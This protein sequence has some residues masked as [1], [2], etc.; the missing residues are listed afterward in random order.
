MFDDALLESRKTRAP[1]ARRLSLPVALG[2]HA[3]VIGAFVGA[4]AWFP[5]EPPEPAEKAVV[6]IVFVPRRGPDSA[7]GGAVQ[8]Q[9]LGSGLHINRR[10]VQPDLSRIEPLPTTTAAETTQSTGEP[11]EFQDDGAGPA[12]GT[13]GDGATGPGGPGS[14]GNGDRGDGD[15]ILPVGGDVRAPI[16]L[17]RLEPDYPEAARRAR[18]QG[19]VILEATI[20]TSGEVQQVRVLKSVNPLLDEAAVR[21]VRVW[22][23]RPAT[24]DGRTV[25][26]YLT[27]TVRFGTDG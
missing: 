4:S 25:P 3:A 13:K 5:G 2:L 22:R 21:A 6:P 15:E 16:L 11:T 14:P 26:V 23:Y 27:V 9:T 1:S 7:G 18:L 8:Q 20:T 10:P 12:D 24:L 19:T 17:E